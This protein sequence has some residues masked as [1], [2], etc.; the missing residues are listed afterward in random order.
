MSA[1]QRRPA[2]LAEIAE[3][4]RHLDP[5]LPRA[6]WLK[7]G[8]ALK[9]ELG[10]NGFELF[11]SWS[12]GGATYSERDLRDVWRSLRGQGVGIG[13][14]FRMAQQSGWR[15]EPSR[16]PSHEPPRPRPTVARAP[17]PDYA[18][19]AARANQTWADAS[20]VLEHDYLIKKDI[21]P[22]GIRW[23]PS[24][25]QHAPSAVRTS[26]ADAADSGGLLAI[27]KRDVAGAIW[28]LEFIDA[29]GRKATLRGPQRPGVHFLIPG[30]DRLIVVAEGYATA[31]AF[32]EAS[33]F[34]CA[35]AFSAGQLCAV[36][37]ELLQAHP[38][39]RLALLPDDD[40]AGQAAAGRARERW[41]G[42]RLLRP[43]WTGLRRGAKDTDYNDAARL[44]AEVRHG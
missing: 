14:L 17:E 25:Y 40:E 3:A 42:L 30:D 15:R 31:A 37:A 4:L 26:S 20:P 16:E 34:S 9:A 13:T 38:L 10:G 8:M 1:R 39:H 28:S 41:P 35:A 36:I 7:V 44:R 27:P 43:D 23:V 12:Q 33:G 24:D 21:R 29:W 5:D 18:A 6:D 32:R 22:Y 2:T 19:T 11:D